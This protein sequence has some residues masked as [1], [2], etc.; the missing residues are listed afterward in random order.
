MDDIV[1]KKEVTTVRVEETFNRELISIG[2]YVEVC[3]YNTNNE[4][5]SKYTGMIIEMSKDIS[6]REYLIVYCYSNRSLKLHRTTIFTIDILE[7]A[8]SIKILN[9]VREE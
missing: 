6:N 3:E 5:K 4:I 1:I 9:K 8:Y 2:D 7:K